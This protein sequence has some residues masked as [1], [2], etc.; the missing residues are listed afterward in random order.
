L[1]FHE[2]LTAFKQAHIPHSPDE[3]LILH[4]EDIVNARGAFW[5]LRHPSTRAAFDDALLGLTQRTEFRVVAVVI[6]KLRLQERYPV[7][8]HPYHLALGFLL[9]RY[10]G[11]LNHVN[12]LGDVMAESRGGAEDR[13]LK[14]SYSRVFERGVWMTAA[15]TMRQALTSKELKPKLANI[16]GL[17]LAD[18]L[19]H[20]VRQQIART[21]GLLSDP[22]APFAGRLLEVLG[23][24]FNRHL[25]DGRVEGYGKVLFPK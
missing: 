16:A 14:D 6:D 25:Y 9:Q 3:P 18:L 21:A 20:P 13:L 11:Y 8:A 15:A 17:Q 4:R 12:R 22:A 2:A 1:P 24:K 10:C 7:P 19:C 5:R 23:P